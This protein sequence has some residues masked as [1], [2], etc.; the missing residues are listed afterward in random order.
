MAILQRITTYNMAIPQRITTYNMAI[1]QRKITYNMAIPQWNWFMSAATEV[2]ESP[3]RDMVGAIVRGPMN[4]R[5]N[6]IRPVH[7]RTSWTIEANIKFPW[8]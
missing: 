8:I 3:I 2:R 5:K 4:L 7:P 1:P 6:P